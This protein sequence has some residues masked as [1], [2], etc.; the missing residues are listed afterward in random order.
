[1][2]PIGVL[3]VGLGLALLAGCGPT[4]EE[5]AA[6]AAAQRASD[7]EKCTGF[8]FT[9]GTDAFARCMMQIV[10]QREAQA[11]ADRRAAQAQAAADQRAQAAAK[12]AADAADQDAWDKRTG[13]GKYSSSS[14][15]ATAA[16]PFNDKN[17]ADPSPQ[18]ATDEQQRA[19]YQQ[20]QKEQEEQGDTGSAGSDPGETSCTETTSSAT[21]AN[22]GSLS[23]ST[24][25][26][27]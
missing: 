27:N 14:S 4:P 1:M 21:G 9:P 23:S 3:A 15:G 10:T 13:Q 6:M 16:S 17:Y 11:A 26:H 19:A 8:G 20:H 18:S 22:S 7:Q 2:R 24:S 25:C 5:Q 12:A